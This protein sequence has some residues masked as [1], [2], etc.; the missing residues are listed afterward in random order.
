MNKLR[1]RIELTYSQR[2]VGATVFA[3]PV[4]KDGTMYSGEQ[5]CI[6]SATPTFETISGDNEMYLTSHA[7]D[8]ADA[9]CIVDLKPGMTPDQI[10]E[11]IARAIEAHPYLS[12]I[13]GDA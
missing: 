7:G 2:Y 3:K 13:A 8:D 4:K 6:G 11:R 12:E 5:C 9:Y 1:D 10:V